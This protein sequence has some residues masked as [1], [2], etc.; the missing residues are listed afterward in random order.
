MASSNSD[1]ILER[2]ED[3]LHDMLYI[4]FQD[5]RNKLPQT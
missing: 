2:A 5:Y 3:T 1:V 4:S